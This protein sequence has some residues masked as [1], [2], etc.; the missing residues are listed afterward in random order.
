MPVNNPNVVLM[1]I[2]GTLLL[3]AA[4]CIFAQQATIET[5]KG[6]IK[7][8]VGNLSDYTD[9]NKEHN[10]NYTKCMNYWWHACDVACYNMGYVNATIHPN[11][12][13]KNSCTCQT[14]PYTSFNPNDYLKEAPN[15]T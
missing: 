14:D 4:V 1:G 11:L 10:L 5:Q 9:M 15:A 8:L 12:D 6:D 3:A 2:F 7:M 13:I